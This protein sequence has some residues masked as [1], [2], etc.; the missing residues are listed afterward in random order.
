VHQQG[1][2][3]GDL[4]AHNILVNPQSSVLLGDF[5][6]ATDFTSL[7]K[8]QQALIKQ[9]EIRAFSHLAEDLLSITQT[10]QA[11]SYLANTLKAFVDYCRTEKSLSFAEL[12]EELT[13]LKDL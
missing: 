9:L 1:I 4:Y 6:A 12:T 8:I 11:G 7:P 10:S 13:Q 2:S 5:G 3:H